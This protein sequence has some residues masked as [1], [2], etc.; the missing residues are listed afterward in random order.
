MA[1]WWLSSVCAYIYTDGTRMVRP[2]DSHAPAKQLAEIWGNCMPSKWWEDAAGK[3]VPVKQSGEAVG[4]C[5][6]VGS[7]EQMLSDS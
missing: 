1:G 4:S 3:C 5:V 2:T 7:L 6:L